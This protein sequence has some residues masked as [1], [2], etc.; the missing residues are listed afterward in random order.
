MGAGISL[1]VFEAVECGTHNAASAAGVAMAVP[2]CHNMFQTGSLV[3]KPP[4]KVADGK[5][6][7]GVALVHVNNLVYTCGRVN[8]IIDNGSR[9]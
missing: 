4:K 7:S 3:R 5:F 6:S 8:R 9:F 1:T 2:D